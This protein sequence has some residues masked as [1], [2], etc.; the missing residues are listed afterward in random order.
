MDVDERLLDELLK[1]PLDELIKHPGPKDIA[2]AV[3]P[4]PI[5]GPS[6][7]PSLDLEDD[8]K[9]MKNLIKKEQHNSHMAALHIAI[10]LLEHYNIDAVTLTKQHLKQ[11]DAKSHTTWQS[12]R[13]CMLYCKRCMKNRGE[14]SYHWYTVASLKY[15]G[16]KSKAQKRAVLYVTAIYPHCS[17]CNVDE[18]WRRNVMMDNRNG[19]RGY[20]KLKLPHKEIIRDTFNVIMEKF[21]TFGPDDDHCGMYVICSLYCYTCYLIVHLCLTIFRY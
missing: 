3:C 12:G 9:E 16:V 2:G 20:E 19:G 17:Q 7:D 11:G 8:S 18:K 15:D 4:D 21:N 5:L 13:S 14:D 6:W 1:H 10:D